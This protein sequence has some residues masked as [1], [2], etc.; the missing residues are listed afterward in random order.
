MLFSIVAERCNR[1]GV[2]MALRRGPKAKTSPAGLSDRLELLTVQ[3]AADVLR[4]SSLTLNKWRVT[5][6]GPRFVKVGGSVRYRVHDLDEYVS[7][8]TRRSTCDP[9]W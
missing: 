4:L 7:N 3:E 2:A 1:H 6:G 8:Q 9:G 5:G